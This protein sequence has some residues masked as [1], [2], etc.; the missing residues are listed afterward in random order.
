MR[1]SAWRKKRRR[2][3]ISAFHL[4]TALAV[5]VVLAA[6]VLFFTDTFGLGSTLRGLLASGDDFYDTESIKIIDGDYTIDAP[7]ERLENT[8]ILGSLY[9]GPGIG[10]GSVDLVNVSVDGSVLVQGGGLQTIYML[11]CDLREVK[12]NRPAGKVRLVASGETVIDGTVLETG[13]RLV[14]NLANGFEGYREIEIATAE[15]VE[16]SGDCDMVRVTVRDAIVDIDSEGLQQLTVA[17]NAAGAIINYPDGFNIFNLALEGSAYL[18]GQAEVEQAVLGGSGITEISGEF[19]RTRVIAEAGH[20]ELGAGSTFQEM[21]VVRNALNNTLNL[22]EGVTIAYLG[23]HEAVTVKGAGEIEKVFINAAGSTFE[24]I[25]QEIEFGLEAGV[26]IAGHEITTP[27]MLEA[28]RQYGDPNRVGPAE[29]AAEPVE[30]SAP[31]SAP[32]PGEPEEEEKPEPPAEQEEQVNEEQQADEGE[33]EEAEEDRAGEQTPRFTLETVRPDENDTQAGL[34]IPP[35]KILAFVSLKS[36]E[37]A[38]YMVSIGAVELR[39]LVEVERFY[40]LVDD[41]GE[42]ELRRQVVIK[43]KSQ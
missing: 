7:G 37:P 34:L 3:K 12:V 41:A 28:L 17:P 24:Q 38:K 19:S 16:L 27:E 22:Q 11:N 36:D 21:V 42:D 26:I 39:Y 14:E 40:A 31:E 32:A 2:K 35:G 20:F 29:E 9:L 18:P 33:G 8:R 23:L 30:D 5:A 10:D 6:G 25:P 15:K 4:I 13:A 43:K 1:R